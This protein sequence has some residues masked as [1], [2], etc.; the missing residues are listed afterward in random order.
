MF[1]RTTALGLCVTIGVV[2]VV[3]PLLV[4]V[5]LPSTWRARY[6]QFFELIHAPVGAGRMGLNV[7]ALLTVISLLQALLVHSIIVRISNRH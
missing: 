4:P 3:H 5:L 6:V 2:A 1:L 7:A